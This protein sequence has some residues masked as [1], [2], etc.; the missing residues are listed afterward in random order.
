MR[1][2]GLVIWNQA[3]RFHLTYWKNLLPILPVLCLPVAGDALYS[4][5]VRQKVQEGTLS[6]RPNRRTSLEARFTAPL[7]EGVL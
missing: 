2:P 4:L 1:F 5:L 6:P 3:V 7:N